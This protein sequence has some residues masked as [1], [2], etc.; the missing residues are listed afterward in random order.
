MSG[1]KAIDLVI[2]NLNHRKENVAFK[3]VTEHGKRGT[4]HGM[5]QQMLQQC[6]SSGS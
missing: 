3:R 2:S 5:M 6:V 1:A 4:G